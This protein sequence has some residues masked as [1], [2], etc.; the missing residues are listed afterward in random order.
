MRLASLLAPHAADLR[1]DELELLLWKLKGGGDVRKALS[2]LVLARLVAWIAAL[3]NLPTGC[4][5]LFVSGRMRRLSSRQ[6]QFVVH[7]SRRAAWVER[8]LTVHGLRQSFAT[9]LYA[10]TKGLLLVQRAMN[11]GSLAST[12]VQ[13]GG[14]R[15]SISRSHG[16]TLACHARRASKVAGAR[17][18]LLPRYSTE[19]PEP[20]AADLLLDFLDELP[21]VSTK[22]RQNRLDPIV[23][24]G[25]DA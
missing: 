4:P 16:C 5:A 22:R 3:E 8:R 10:K 11:H 25:L 20:L 15:P 1:L 7:R 9:A 14:G 6:V 13:G 21:A 24:S 23:E 12:M 19:D 17:S 2:E 18:T